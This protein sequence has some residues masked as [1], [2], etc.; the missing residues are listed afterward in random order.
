LN[1]IKAYNILAKQ[2]FVFTKGC[3]VRTKRRFIFLKQPLIKILSVRHAPTHTFVKMKVG[4][5]ENIVP[6]HFLKRKNRQTL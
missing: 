5:S 1:I 6:L 2:R 4:I 3:F